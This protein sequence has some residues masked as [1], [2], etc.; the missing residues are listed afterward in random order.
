MSRLLLL[1]AL[2]LGCSDP[3]SG[4]GAALDAR[5]E[6][7]CCDVG[8]ALE[9]C[10]EGGRTSLTWSDVGA[11]DR[12]DFARQCSDDWDRT[13]ADLTAYELQEATGVCQDTRKDLDALDCEALGALYRPQP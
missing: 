4:L 6:R 5:C 13:S 1:V 9:T 3:C 7:L 11:V 10:I 8:A 2:S 12:R